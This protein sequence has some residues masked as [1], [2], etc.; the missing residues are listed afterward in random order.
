MVRLGCFF[1]LNRAKD[2]RGK[3]LR[4]KMRLCLLGPHLAFVQ[5]FLKLYHFQLAS[6]KEFIHLFQFIGLFEKLL[7]R[8]LPFR[9]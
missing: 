7:L 9:C 8:S 2:H 3:R 1:G 5:F 4:K 6:D